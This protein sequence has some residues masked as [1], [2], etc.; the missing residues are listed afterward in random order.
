[1][2]EPRDAANQIGKLVLSRRPERQRR[3]CEPFKVRPAIGIR[4]A[5]RSLRQAPRF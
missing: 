5:P 3:W 2:V 4:L 1:L